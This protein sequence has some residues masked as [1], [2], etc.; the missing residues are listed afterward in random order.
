MLLNIFFTSIHGF[1]PHQLSRPSI[2]ATL[3]LAKNVK[4]LLT[5]EKNETSNEVHVQNHKKRHSQSSLKISL[6][7]IISFSN[8]LRRSN[9]N[10]VN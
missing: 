8:K 6:T 10:V 4:E 5:Y 3:R 7:K 1:P 9:L 2:E